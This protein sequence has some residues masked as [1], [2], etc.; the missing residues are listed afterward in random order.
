MSA[1]VYLS[2]HSQCCVSCKRRRRRCGGPLG[3]R[4][5]CAWF[6]CILCRVQY[7]YERHVEWM[8]ALLFDILDLKDITL[9][10]QDWGGLIGLRYDEPCVADAWV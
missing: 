2:A 5:C 4:D 6:Y 10:C 7:T 9:V 1:N 8:R 3:C